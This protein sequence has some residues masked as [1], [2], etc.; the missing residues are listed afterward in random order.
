MSVLA[1]RRCDQVLNDVARVHDVPGSSP[2][3]RRPP[4]A[5][6]SGRQARRLAAWGLRVL[7]D[8]GAQIDT[9]YRGRSPRGSAS[10]RR[11]PSSSG[12]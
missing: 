3:R 12:S 4:C 6:R 7:V 10:S 9:T 2:G 11:W 8:Q 1:S 5:G